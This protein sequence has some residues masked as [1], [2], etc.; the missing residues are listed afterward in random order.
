LP[1]FRPIF[2]IFDIISLFDVH[3]SPPPFHA[4]FI[5][6]SAAV[7]I[8]RLPVFFFSH[9]RHALLFI[10][11]CRFIVIFAFFRC[12]QPFRF[13]IGP[14][15]TPL[16]LSLRIFITTFSSS[17]SSRLPFHDIFS[18]FAMPSFISFIFIFFITPFRRLLSPMLSASLHFHIS[19]ASL[20]ISSIAFSFLH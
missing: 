16:I 17:F 10:F 2:D 13:S 1:F 19:S 20:H 15:I 9:A 12:R 3:V 18:I 11:T 6:A 4:R 5:F 7:L 8:R 14:D